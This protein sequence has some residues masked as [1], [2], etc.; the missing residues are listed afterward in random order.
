MPLLC[1]QG[2]GC[3]EGGCPESKEWGGGGWRAEASSVARRFLAGPQ[4][5]A[6]PFLAEKVLWRLRTRPP[7]GSGQC[8]S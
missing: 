4:G 3:L 5:H 7:G 6:V 1:T 8:L 2:R